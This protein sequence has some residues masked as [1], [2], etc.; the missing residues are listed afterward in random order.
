MHWNDFSIANDV[1]NATP[2]SRTRNNAPPSAANQFAYSLTTPTLTDLPSLN[3]CVSLLTCALTYTKLTYL[4]Q[5]APPFR[6]YYCYTLAC[7]QP[8][9]NR[10][11]RGCKDRCIAAILRADG[12]AL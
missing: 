4:Q 6:C 1:A 9:R 7:F 10:L 8:Q 2:E 12:R 11:S 3:G 5:H